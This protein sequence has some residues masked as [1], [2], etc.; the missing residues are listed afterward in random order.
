MFDLVNGGSGGNYSVASYGS[1]E[2]LGELFDCNE[3]VDGG[4]GAGRVLSFGFLGTNL[5]PNPGPEDVLLPLIMLSQ[6]ARDL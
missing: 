6:C 2:W 1:W 3:A 5:S 4:L